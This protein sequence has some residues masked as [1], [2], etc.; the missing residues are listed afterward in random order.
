MLK[1]TQKQ[2]THSIKIVSQCKFILLE[3]YVWVVIVDDNVYN[4]LPKYDFF[5]TAD[6]DED[7]YNEPYV[8][9][10][11]TEYSNNNLS[12]IIQ[13]KISSFKVYCD[14]DLYFKLKLVV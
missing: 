13:Y 1:P 11:P 4:L 12:I 8:V 6:V 2:Y 14:K 9:M 10:S 5:I 7:E 3:D